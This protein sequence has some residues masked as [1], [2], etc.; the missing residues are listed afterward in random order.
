MASNSNQTLSICPFQIASTLLEILS[1]DPS[2]GQPQT[3][4]RP[5]HSPYPL[6]K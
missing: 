6:S 4:D 3:G 5:P 2:H 1:L